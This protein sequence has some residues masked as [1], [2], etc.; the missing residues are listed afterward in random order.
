MPWRRASMVWTINIW[1]AAMH[2]YDAF[3]LLRIYLRPKLMHV[4][5]VLQLAP[6]TSAPLAIPGLF[7]FADE[8][9]SGDIVLC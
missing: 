2:R 6:N 5:F 1:T 3:Q 8:S 7:R 9:T 4:P